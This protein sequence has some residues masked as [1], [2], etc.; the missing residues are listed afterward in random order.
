M[1]GEILTAVVTPFRAD[2]SVDLDAFRSLCGFLV[3][4]G[5]DGVVVTGTTGE[6]PTLSD[7]ER[8]ALYEAAVETL[9][10]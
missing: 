1:L 5:S 7:D 6:A 3:E 9:A 4:N 10:G 2:G 8:L